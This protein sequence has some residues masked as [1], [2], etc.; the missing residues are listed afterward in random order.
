VSICAN[1]TALA[2]HVLQTADASRNV[3]SEMIMGLATR[4]IM[5]L[6]NCICFSW[7]GQICGHYKSGNRWRT[8]KS[9]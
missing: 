5:I 3:G 2:E 6:T 4:I 8:S 1:E 7:N 9:T